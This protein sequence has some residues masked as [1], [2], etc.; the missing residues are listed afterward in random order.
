MDKLYAQNIGILKYWAKRYAR[1]C[2]SRAYVDSEDL[3]QAGCIGLIDAAKTFDPSMGA[4]S[5]WAS[6]HIRK[7]MRHTLGLDTSKDTYTVQKPDGSTEKRRYVITSL[8]AP[9]YVDDDIALVDTIADET[10]IDFDSRL[11]FDEDAK[12][13]HA[14]L[15]D[16]DNQNARTAVCGKYLDGKTYTAIAQSMGTDAGK[17]RRW[18]GEGLRRLA[19]DKRIMAI[20]KERRGLDENTRFH[21]HKGVAAFWYD[22]SSVVEDAVL[23][24]EEQCKKASRLVF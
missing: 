3:F 21:A 6:F 14:A 2:T 18:T 7:A 8:D 15:N 24:R 1:S 16:L 19:Q 10:P 11:F 4:W 13:L 23:W 9:A 12:R 20:R 17:V 5:T 22:H